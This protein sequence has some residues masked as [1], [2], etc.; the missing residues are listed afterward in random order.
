MNVPAFGGI[1]VETSM[2]K[3][4]SEA[5]RTEIP[6]RTLLVPLLTLIYQFGNPI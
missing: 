3:D 6:K 2:R 4:V 1:G 5:E